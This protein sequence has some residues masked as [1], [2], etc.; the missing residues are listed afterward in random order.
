MTDSGDHKITLVAPPDDV[1]TVH[2]LL[3]GVWAD[4]PSVSAID[5][6]S[7]ETA[8]IELASNVLRHAAGGSGVRC[9][10]IIEVT[11]GRI[12][13]RL[14]DTG[15]T[16]DIDLLPRAMPD[17]LS[18]A[19]RGIPLIQALVDELEYARSGSLNHWRISRT[20]AR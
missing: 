3:D 12:E 20:L 14:S 16:G 2:G 17:D 18:E 5:R 1:D 13:A 11:D 10:L 4:F 7:F 9:D 15:L 6:A 19:G 8:L